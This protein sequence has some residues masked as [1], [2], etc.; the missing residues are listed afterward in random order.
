M[1]YLRSRYHQLRIA[2]NGILKP[3][4]VMDFMSFDDVIWGNKYANNVY[5][6]DFFANLISLLVFPNLK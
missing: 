1:I 4:S 3:A 6:F 2:E 5:G